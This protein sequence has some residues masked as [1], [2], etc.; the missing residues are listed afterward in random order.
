MRKHYAGCY[1]RLAAQ[2]ASLEKGLDRQ[3]AATSSV[4]YVMDDTIVKPRL[5]LDNDEGAKVTF[6][7][8]KGPSIEICSPF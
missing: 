4:L 6:I 7:G 5:A 3:A 8:S 2:L 1:G